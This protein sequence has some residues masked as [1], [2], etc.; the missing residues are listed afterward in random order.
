[1]NLK[2]DIHFN[3]AMLKRFIKGLAVV[4]GFLATL[5]VLAILGWTGYLISKAIDNTPDPAALQAGQ[6]ELTANQVRFDKATIAALQ[7]LVPLNV[8][9]NVNNLG[10]AD[11][12]NP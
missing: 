6:E 2:L 12:F 7:S 11:P 9:P 3:P 10:H 1:M 5:A 4:Q 8:Q